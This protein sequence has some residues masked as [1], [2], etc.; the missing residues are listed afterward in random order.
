MPEKPS[1]RPPEYGEPMKRK[2][3]HLPPSLI[4]HATKVGDG[5][6]AKGV[7]RCIERDMEDDD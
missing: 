5:N 6:L 1:H 4:E 3:I 7:R 2:N